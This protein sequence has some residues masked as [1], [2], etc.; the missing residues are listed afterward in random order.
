MRYPICEMTFL[1]LASERPAHLIYL[2]R[3]LPFSV[4][5]GITMLYAVFGLVILAS[6]GLALYAL[7]NKGELV[8]H[9]AAL[10]A[11]VEEQEASYSAEIENLKR[12]MGANTSGLEKRLRE[13]ALEASAMVADLKRENF[14]IIDDLNAELAKLEKL[15]HIP[16]IIEKSRKLEAEI[17]AKLS[18]AQ[19]HAD[20]TVLI[21]HKDSE[22][23]KTRIAVKLE[24]A[25][26]RAHNLMLDASTRAAEIAK[27][28]DWDAKEIVKRALSSVEADTAK[29]RDFVL[30]A[31]RRARDIVEAAEVEAKGIASQARKEAKEKTQKVDET[32]AKAAA[33]ALEIRKNAD[34]RGRE[35]AGQAYEALKRYEFYEAAAKAKENVIEGYANTYMVPASHVLDELAEEYGFHNAGERL[36]IARDYTRVMD[37][38]GLAATCNYPEGWKRDYAIS[39]VLGAFNGKV[40]S[41][42]ARLK[43]ANQGKLIQEI[44]DVYAL[45]NHNG[46]VFKEAR[47]HEEYLVA[48]LEELKW[49][50]AVQRVKEKQREEQRAIREQMRDEEKARKEIERAI[51]QSE[52]EE[53]TIAKAFERARQEYESANAE[54]RAKYEAKLEDLAQKLSE[55]EEKNRRAISMAQQTKRG[56]VY[57]ISNI[58][59]FGEDVYKIGLTRRLE[60]MDRVKELGDASVPFAFDVHAMIQS[61]DAPALEAALH[62]RFSRNQVNKVNRRKE[63]FRL[64]LQD[65]RSVID[66]LTPEV[67]W[68]MAAEAR[69]YRDSLVMERHLE[70]D[71]EFR[72]QWT[73]SEVAYEAHH[74]FDDDETDREDGD[75]ALAEEV[76]DR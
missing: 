69:D 75:V 52:R 32:L 73:E 3:T 41:I 36:K 55:A 16:G 47:I 7:I 70:E 45:T 60:P 66:D 30:E 18:Q 25:E 1:P 21:A 64:K 39:F 10:Q 2:L 14:A 53:E 57:V 59:S 56:N 72:R 51:K 40:D 19:E 6:V 58:G 61:D 27:S 33:Y 71:P 37:K 63:F 67:K 35:L 44:K 4:R 8:A 9:I 50:V 49:A 28:A 17:A 23:I 68:T 62:R 11:E 5:W 76:N 20:E 54:D 65:I 46:Q 29:A 31:N 38:N 26:R 15:K 13:Q 74:M 24:E 48:R 22:R 43:P 34:A 12:E 42:L